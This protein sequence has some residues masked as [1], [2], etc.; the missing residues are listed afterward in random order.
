MLRTW[1]YTSRLILQV[2]RCEQ[3]VTEEQAVNQGS[4]W[5]RLVHSLACRLKVAPDQ[6][7]YFPVIVHNSNLNSNLSWPTYGAQELF[8]LQPSLKITPAAGFRFIS[9]VTLT[10]LRSASDRVLLSGSSRQQLKHG[11][12]PQRTVLSLLEK[13]LSSERAERVL[14]SSFVVVI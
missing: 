8:I 7:C 14:F 11:S 3:E 2:S 5:G 12:A 1:I 4:R 10:V 6:R 13:S 9:M